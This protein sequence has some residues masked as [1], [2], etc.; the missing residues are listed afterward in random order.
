MRTRHLAPQFLV[1]M[2]PAVVAVDRV[3]P[4][5]AAVSPSGA[6][7]DVV[8]WSGLI[9]PPAAT[10][11]PNRRIAVEGDRIAV[12]DLP[13]GQ[14]VA[15]SIDPA[16]VLAAARCEPAATWRHPRLLAAIP[17]SVG[18]WEFRTQRDG[19]RL[20]AEVT[21]GGSWSA[22]RGSIVAHAVLEDVALVAIR[23]A[24]VRPWALAPRHELVVVDGQSAAP[25]PAPITPIDIS[26]HCWPLR[27]AD[28]VPLLRDY[29]KYTFG[30]VAVLRKRGARDV[31][32]HIA[33][34]G[35]NPVIE[36][37]FSLDMAPGR[38]FVRRDEP[39]DELGNLAG[40]AF[41]NIIFD[42][43]DFDLLAEGP[44]DDQ[45]RVLV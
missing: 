44:V 6:V 45:G 5:A 37:E 31:R 14:P 11:W 4:V 29:L 21:H 7:L 23:R 35:A 18:P 41:W 43:E 16:G 10:A 30:D 1:A 42:D 39:F 20:T 12:Q 9:R 17:R 34:I 24:D 8:S 15:L 36:V 27:R 38:R 2:G 26:D 22:G 19:Y 25:R 32:V 28:S 3:Q 40:L 33:G 13:D